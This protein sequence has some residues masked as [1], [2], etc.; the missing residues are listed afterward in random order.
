MR[1]K[2]IVLCIAWVLV[3]AFTAPGAAGA[4]PAKHRSSDG[5]VPAKWDMLK[6]AVGP[7][8]DCAPL[9]AGGNGDGRNSISFSEFEDGDIVV[10]LGTATGH[11]GEWDDYYHVTDNSACVWSANTTPSNDVLREAPVKYRAYD[12]AYGLWV[13]SVS[14]TNRVRARNY[15]RAQKGEVYD[16]GSAKTNQSR[17]YCSKLAWASYKY[18]VNLDLDGDGGYW[19]WP[20]D[21]VTDPST[22]V[23]ARGV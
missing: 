8:E 22:S 7:H 4:A 9:S 1:K 2:C 6:P 18:T 23:F 16:I 21:L 3:A 19:V 20:V 12:E 17:W 10:V 14:V 5:T 13:P 15:C 11:A